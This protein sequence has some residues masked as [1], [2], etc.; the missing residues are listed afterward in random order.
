MQGSHHQQFHDRGDNGGQRQRVFWGANIEPG[1]ALRVIAG[2]CGRV[3]SGAR[4]LPVSRS[5]QPRLSVAGAPMAVAAGMIYRGATGGSDA[6]EP[7]DG[8]RVETV[9]RQSAAAGPRW[10]RWGWSRA[11]GL[12]RRPRCGTAPTPDVPRP[13]AGVEAVSQVASRGGFLAVPAIIRHRP[14]RLVR[15]IANPDRVRG[16]GPLRLHAPAGLRVSSDYHG[17]VGECRR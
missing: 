17:R 9:S 3:A 5:R 14:T 12:S 4:I 7:E 13:A 6:G 2:R 10:R 16:V 15:Q 8:A 1:T 11:T